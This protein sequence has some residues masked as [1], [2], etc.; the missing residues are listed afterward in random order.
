MM[1]DPLTALSLAGN[2]IQLVDFSSKLVNKGREIYRA[3]DVALPENLELEIVAKDLTTLVQRLMN[4]P[5]SDGDPSVSFTDPAD[6]EL[7]Q[8]CEKC[9][10]TATELLAKLQEV[11]VKGKH[12]RWKS[13]RQALK[14]VWTKDEVDGL[15]RR[16]A[17]FRNQLQF[18]I[19]VSYA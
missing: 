14:S 11:K 17:V 4:H 6:S 16:L 19:M 12:R 3:V 18:R 10:T 1:L 9:K 15:A 2:I 7:Y 5:G 13:F 8:I